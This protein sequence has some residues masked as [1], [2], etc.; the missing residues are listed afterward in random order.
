[1]FSVEMWHHF[2]WADNS[3]I[4][5]F[6]V[7]PVFDVIFCHGLPFYENC[8]SKSINDIHLGVLLHYVTEMKINVLLKGR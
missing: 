8:F 3:N 7:L 5:D 2:S 1:M 6:K 4:V